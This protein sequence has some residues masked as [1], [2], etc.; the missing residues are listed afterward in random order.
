MTIQPRAKGTSSTILENAFTVEAPE[1]DFTE[2]TSGSSGEEITVNGFFFGIKKGKVTL[3]G[4][5]CKVLRWTI[6]DPTTKE[7]E[8]RFVVP[9]GLSSGSQELKIAN[10]VA[11]DTINFVVK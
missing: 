3:G 1:I 4:K 9:K 7:S 6:M 11:A 2:P 5:N 8:I 10:G